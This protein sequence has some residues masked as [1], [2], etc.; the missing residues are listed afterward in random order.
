MHQ[1]SASGQN[2][3][4]GIINQ[5]G[6]Y[7][8]IPAMRVEEDDSVKHSLIYSMGKMQEIILINA[9]GLFNFVGL[10]GLHKLTFLLIIER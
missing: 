7:S 9:G 3:E 8:L 5:S 6:L 4:T 10:K 1:I 2:R